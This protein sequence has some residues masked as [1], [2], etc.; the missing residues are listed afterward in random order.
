MKEFS[1]D[2]TKLSAD[3]ARKGHVKSAIDL[4][5]YAAAAIEKGEE[6]P[7]GLRNWLIDGLRAI[8][9]LDAADKHLSTKVAKALN[10]HRKKGRQYDPQTLVNKYQ[11][12]SLVDSFHGTDTNLFEAAE[13][14]V[15]HAEN[16]DRWIL[17]LVPNSSLD[18]DS[19]SNTFRTYY[20]EMREVI[21]DNKQLSREDT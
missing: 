19:L 3:D 1:F 14:A 17:E 13:L 15:E 16:H 7:E 10:L 2:L 21:E 9:N 8:G 4:A 11:I 18:S 5:A 12:A 20:I 6:L